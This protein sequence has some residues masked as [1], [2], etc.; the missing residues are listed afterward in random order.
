M[1]LLSASL[2]VIQ[3]SIYSMFLG[4]VTM[5]DSGCD[6]PVVMPPLF[7][8]QIYTLSHQSWNTLKKSPPD[9]YG[10]SLAIWSILTADEM[11]A[12]LYQAGRRWSVTDTRD[13]ANNG[14][15]HMPRISKTLYRCPPPLR[16]A[17]LDLYMRTFY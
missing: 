9:I 13:E 2:Q 10:Q 12:Y 7:F 8:F 1:T 11:F 4:E 6:L 16:G 14:F 17:I 15:L 3:V 5:Q